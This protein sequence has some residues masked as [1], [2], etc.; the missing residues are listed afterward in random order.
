MTIIYKFCNKYI[1]GFNMSKIH[2]T[3]YEDNHYSNL[4]QKLDK[5]NKD[6]DMSDMSDISDLESI[7]TVDN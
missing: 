2:V 3:N 4:Y 1:C 5:V 6:S 7:D